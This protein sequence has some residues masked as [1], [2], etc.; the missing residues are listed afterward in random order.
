MNYIEDQESIEMNRAIIDKSIDITIISENKTFPNISKKRMYK[1][2]PIC[3]KRIKISYHIFCGETCFK[4][5]FQG[6]NIEII[7]SLELKQYIKSL[8]YN[9]ISKY[10][11]IRT[12]K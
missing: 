5:I 10:N 4:S 6:Q 11:H 8:E 1:F 2:C 3:K 12:P 7:K 9:P